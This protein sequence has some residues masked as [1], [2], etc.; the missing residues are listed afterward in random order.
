M[1][2]APTPL[3]AGNWTTEEWHTA[4]EAVFAKRTTYPP[5][6]LSFIYRDIATNLQAELTSIRN[7]HADLVAALQ[8]LYE[9]TADYIR[10]NNLGDV[11]HNR[12]MQ[13]ARAA[14]A[15]AGEKV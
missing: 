1:K 9:E 12:S 3:M 6:S 8:V 15:K 14:L 7:S 4:F 5:D 11:H 2:H 10:I 13:M